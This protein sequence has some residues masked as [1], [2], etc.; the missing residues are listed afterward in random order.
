MRVHGT[1]RLRPAEVFATDEQPTLNPVPED[2]FDLPT[3]AHPKVAP[4]QHV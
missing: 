4:D 3:W 1:T 2:K